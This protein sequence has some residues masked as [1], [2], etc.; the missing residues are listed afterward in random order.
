MLKVHNPETAV[1]KRPRKIKKRWRLPPTTEIMALAEVLFRGGICPNGCNRPEHLAARIVA[2]FELGLNPVQAIGNIM[3]VN[4]RA[5][6]WGDAALALVVASDLLAH[7]DEF[8]EG[9]GGDR[10]GVCLVARD[11]FEQRRFTFSV[12]QAKEAKL[13]GKSGP[14]T[15][16]PD[17]ML[18]MR[19]RGFALR[20]VF[21]DVLAGLN[22]AEEA[23]DV[24]VSNTPRRDLP[25]DGAAVSANAEIAPRTGKQSGESLGIVGADDEARK[26]ITD[27]QLNRIANNRPSWARSRGVD[28]TDADAVGQLWKKYLHER[29]NVTTAKQLSA[30]QADIVIAEISDAAYAQ[31]S[32][33]I[34]GPVAT[35]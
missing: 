23:L 33:E 6:V 31:Q 5:A 25:V 21:P 20:D 34:F 22:I 7:H 24:E 11:G 3:L 4:G 15:N 16:Y 1:E 35:T 12:G 26:P 17:R 29:F 19:A 14:W 32:H 9:D 30:K 13:W 27:E 8:I 2:G 18:L 28:S 10:V